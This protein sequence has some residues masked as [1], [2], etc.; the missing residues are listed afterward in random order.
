MA[1][2]VTLQMSNN[3]LPRWLSEG[4]SVFEETRARPEWGREMEVA[5][6]RALDSGEVLKL[7]DLNAGFQNPRT[8]SLAYYEASLLVDHIVQKHG[9]PALRAFVRSF[10]EGV[11]TEGAIKKVLASDIDALQTTFDGYLEKRFAALRTS[12]EAPEGFA[13]DAPLDRLKAAA[14]ANPT[15]FP[16]LMSLAQ[17][18]RQTDAQ[19]SI[20][21]FEQA[22]KVVPMITGPES[23][24]MQIVE[25]A[26]ASGNKAKAAE[27]LD[28]MTA[29]DHTAVDAARQ[30][31]GLLDPVKDKDRLRVALQ[32]V[33]AVDPFDA[34]AHSQL[35]R[36]ALASGQAAEAVKLFRVALAAGP[37]DKASAHADL[38]E[39][40]FQ[41]G[42]KAQ[43]KREALAAL[44]IA[45]TFER[46]QDLLLKLVEGGR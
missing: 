35:G 19:A 43:A 27:A 26:M 25:V 40:L 12:L 34:S 37:V 36:M 4:I 18:L 9:E 46:A 22:A 15:S 31:A 29:V 45:P 16:V 38:A 28:A 32:R 23:P 13:P 2:V 17:A 7:R 8:I 11:D 42:D 41:T 44:E 1:H 30:L 33:V 21:V 5:F 39:G 6:A 24:Y 10:G 14:A 20:P 3:R